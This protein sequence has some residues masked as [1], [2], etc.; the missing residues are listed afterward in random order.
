MLVDSYNI[1]QFLNKNYLIIITTNRI[2]KFK[3][4]TIEETPKPTKLH[5]KKLISK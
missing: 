3:Y 2:N 5:M 4:F 1:F